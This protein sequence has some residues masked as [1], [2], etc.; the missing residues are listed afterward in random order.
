MPYTLRS[1]HRFPVRCYVSY[2]SKLRD[3]HGTIFNLSTHGWRLSG[4]LSLQPGDICTLRVILPT[5][6]RVTVAAGRVRWVRGNA[7][8]IETL[9]ITDEATEIVTNYLQARINTFF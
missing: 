1:Y 2:E 3:G 6:Q 5:S 4:D 7:C 9:V 8:G